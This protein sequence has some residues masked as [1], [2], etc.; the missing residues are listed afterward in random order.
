MGDLGK[1]HRIHAIINDHQVEYQS[2]VL[3]TSGKI[4]GMDF[5]LLIDPGATESFISHTVLSRS[6]VMARKIEDF[7]V[8]EM[9]SDITQEVGLL[10]N[11]CE[12]DLGVCV[13]KVSLYT[14][15]LG[16]YD[17][18]IGMYWLES[19]EAV[20]DCKEKRLIF[21]D[22]L[23]YKKI[24]VGAKRGISLRFILALQLKKSFKKGCK[25]YVVKA[26]NN[27]NDTI[28]VSQHPILSNFGDVFPEEFPR[29]HQKG[30]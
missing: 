5:S 16:S 12:V 9:A 8:V 3:E 22:D 30:N 18:I 26:M 10:V 23:G 11:E 13:T 24:L 21:I 14:T 25:L 20:L 29:L 27:K 15:S 2:I 4:N 1:A 7:D 19:H 28:D 6:K 17:I